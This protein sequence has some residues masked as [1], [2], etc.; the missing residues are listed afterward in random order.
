MIETLFPDSVKNILDY[1]AIKAAAIRYVENMLM[2]AVIEF[3]NGQ[4]LQTM[5]KDQLAVIADHISSGS[6]MTEANEI[7]SYMNQDNCLKE[8]EF[9]QRL[10][11]NFPGVHYKFFDVTGYGFP[12]TP[13][14]AEEAHRYE[15]YDSPR[16][17]R[18]PPQDL[19]WEAATPSER[20]KFVKFMA[21]RNSVTD[22]HNATLKSSGRRG[23]WGRE[24]TWM[25][26]G[27]F[28]KPAM[29][30]LDITDGV[31]ESNGLLAI[32]NWLDSMSY[33]IPLNLYIEINNTIN[34][35]TDF[36]NY[37][38]SPVKHA[39]PYNEEEIYITGNPDKWIYGI[40]ED[41]VP[42]PDPDPDPP[43]P[44]PEPQPPVVD[45]Y[46]GSTTTCPEGTSELYT[47]FFWCYGF[48][49]ASSSNWY[50]PSYTENPTPPVNDGNYSDVGGTR[51]EIVTLT[52]G[53]MGTFTPTRFRLAEWSGMPEFYM[54][55]SYSSQDS[56][57][58]GIVIKFGNDAG[59]TRKFKLPSDM[60]TISGTTIT[61]DLTHPLMVLLDGVLCY[62]SEY[63]T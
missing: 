27:G 4:F 24:D 23:S 57:R 61:W 8:S 33:Q 32:E 12:E 25:T 48:A 26:T 45:I 15:G 58:N 53:V 20:F 38:E 52:D 60:Y 40:G 14:W 50:S 16:P 35:D 9:V 46:V 22:W 56:A 3:A 42:E 11:E 59:V 7:I 37:P 17:G 1:D 36:E 39:Y 41:P 55:E 43:P 5:S 34:V 28:G 44:D 54:E 2:D 21:V 51:Y 6:S 13:D 31:I 47:D 29:I 62:T 10:S 63:P 18:N 19:R 49:N 30:Q